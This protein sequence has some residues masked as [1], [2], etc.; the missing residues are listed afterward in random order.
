MTFDHK[1]YLAKMKPQGDEFDACNELSKAYIGI[2]STPIVDDD[3]PAV[4]HAYESAL[5]AFLRACQANG[6]ALS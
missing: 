6:R 1:A 5:R 3:Y 4:R 2:T